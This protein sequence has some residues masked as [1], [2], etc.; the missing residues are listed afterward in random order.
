MT[1]IYRT[2]TAV[3]YVLTAGFGEPLTWIH[4]S[5]NVLSW[6]NRTSH[7]RHAT[8]GFGWDRIHLETEVQTGDSPIHAISIRNTTLY[9][10][11]G[12][13]WVFRHFSSGMFSCWCKFRMTLFIQSS[14]F[15]STLPS[16]MPNV[17]SGLV[18]MWFTSRMP[19]TSYPSLETKV[20]TT[21]CCQL[22]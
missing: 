3:N 8:H 12:L 1:L 21:D 6:F 18:I 4:H 19:S 20:T 11:S 9:L 2:S 13:L 17:N 22:R 14:E 7:I 15:K 10:S 16:E 5:A